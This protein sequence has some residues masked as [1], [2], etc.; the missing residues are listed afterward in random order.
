MRP[1]AIELDELG[2]PDVLPPALARVERHGVMLILSGGSVLDWNGLAFETLD[3]VD[4]FLA[5][6]HCDVTRHAWARERLRYVYNQALNF[7][8]E[9]LG[10]TFPQEIRRPD[11]VRGALIEASRHGFHRL[12]IQ[13]CA[14]LKLMHVINHLEMQELRSQLAI[15]DVDLLDLANRM[16]EARAAEMRQ[17]GIRIH[18]FYGSRKTRPSVIA[19]LMAKREAT[20][21]T[22]YDKLR[23][24]IV[25]ESRDELVPALGWLLRHLIPFPAVLP[26]E[27]HNNLLSAEEVRAA[28]GE[29]PELAWIFPSEQAP[30]SSF[31]P[32]SASSYRVINFVADLPVRVYDLP[33]I[34][35]PVHRALLG[36]AVSVLVEFQILDA[37]TDAANE[38]GDARHE[39]YKERQLGVVRRRLGKGG[40]E[41]RRDDRARGGR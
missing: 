18:A 14:V 24:R 23:F 4:R 39:I 31:N 26:G 2:V 34:P 11:D 5:L 27:S 6:W 9:Q 28:L 35:P 16:I 33:N 8:E 30:I 17:S 37:A 36:E 25:T 21:A 38:K 7:L 40:S 15:R 10:L 19:K 29:M 32:H 12:R 3:E 1:D 22:V 20:A 41:R 13:H